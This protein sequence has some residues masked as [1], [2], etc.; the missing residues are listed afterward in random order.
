M[1]RYEALQTWVH[2]QFIFLLSYED[3]IF[4]IVEHSIEHKPQTPAIMHHSH[5]CDPNQTNKEREW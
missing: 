5:M 1:I 3:N 4:K 2:F